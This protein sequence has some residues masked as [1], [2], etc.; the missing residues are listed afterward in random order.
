M[1]KRTVRLRCGQVAVWLAV[2][3]QSEVVVGTDDGSGEL[4]SLVY[5]FVG[6]H[7][8]HFGSAIKHEQYDADVS[9][10]ITA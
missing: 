4:L 5:V 7:R 1:L 8:D 2:C 3:L 9:P 10:R 6:R